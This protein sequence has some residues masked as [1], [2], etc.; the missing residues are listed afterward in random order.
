MKILNLANCGRSSGSESLL[1]RCLR[2]V[3]PKKE[4]VKPEIT[5]K[6]LGNANDYRVPRMWENPEKFKDNYQVK[7]I[8]PID[9]KKYKDHT[10]IFGTSSNNIL[11][12]DILNK[13]GHSIVYHATERSKAKAL[14]K[15]LSPEL[16]QLL[17]DE[18]VKT[19][20][21][22]LSK[23]TPPHAESISRICGKPYDTL[24]N[25]TKNRFRTNS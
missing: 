10:L 24:S 15:Y 6:P 5:L 4:Y 8:I 7:G 21:E 1:Q 23:T 2:K 14:K 12:M 9:T 17:Y 11:V 16:I 25:K 13:K 18:A 20:S 22:T 19:T 3:H